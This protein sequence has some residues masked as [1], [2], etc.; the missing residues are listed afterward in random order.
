[1]NNFSFDS[2]INE[3]LTNN[4]D[5]VFD[6]NNLGGEMAE[7]PLIAKDNDIIKVIG[8]DSL[9]VTIPKSQ[10]KT[11]PSAK[12]IMLMIFLAIRYIVC[13]KCGGVPKA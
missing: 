3:E 1:M 10:S 6:V 11:M 7:I 8:D 5:W 4:D 9:Q 12:K 2:R 13:P